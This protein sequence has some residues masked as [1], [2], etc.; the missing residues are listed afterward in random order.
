MDDVR[1]EQVSV[2]SELAPIRRLSHEA[3]AALIAEAEQEIAD[4]KGITGTEL[5]RFLAWFVSEDDG[6]PPDGPDEG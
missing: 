5:E 4:G 2:E 1:A 6:P 3:E